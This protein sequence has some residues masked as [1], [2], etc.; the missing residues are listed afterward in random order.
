MSRCGYHH[1]IWN[2]SLTL[3]AL[4]IRIRPCFVKQPQPL[5]GVRM[6]FWC[7]FNMGTILTFIFGSNP[8]RYARLG[9]VWAQNVSFLESVRNTRFLLHTST[10][11]EMRI[12]ISKEKWVVHV[13]AKK[14][15]LNLNWWINPPLLAWSA[16]LRDPAYQTQCVLKLQHSTSPV[17]HLHSQGNGFYFLYSCS[18]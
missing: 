18:M 1:L 2:N 5:I 10:H 16:F 17:E 13:K 11:H 9:P 15:W 14:I 4:R 3:F 7:F 8:R 6:R 12:E